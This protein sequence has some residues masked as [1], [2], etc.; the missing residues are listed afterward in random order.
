MP[1][2]SEFF[3]MSIYMYWFDVQKHH[4]PHVHVRFGGNEAVFALD[5]TLLEGDIGARARRLVAE[6][7][8][9]RA[10]EL[11]IAWE[12]ASNGREIPW[13]APLR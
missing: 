2:I 7:C 11:R 8:T 10:E 4:R 9:E 12:H 13:V 5:G 1:R 3:G 6:W